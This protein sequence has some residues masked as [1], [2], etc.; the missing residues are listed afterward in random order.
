M[1]SGT[2]VAMPGRHCQGE[3]VEGLCL[4]LRLELCWPHVHQAPPKGLG[5][6]GLGFRVQGLGFKVVV[7][8]GPSLVHLISQGLEDAQ[9]R[10][11]SLGHT[12][13]PRPPPPPPLLEPSSLKTQSQLL[14]FSSE[15]QGA[16]SASSGI[17]ILK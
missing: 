8:G 15:A 4:Q 5:F 9:P 7:P 17:C 10:F 2:I 6:R 12:T 16:C 3:A 11:C 13:R 14:T 1:G